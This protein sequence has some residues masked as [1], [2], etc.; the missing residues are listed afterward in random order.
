MP[1][2][3][4][5]TIRRVNTICGMNR[6]VFNGGRVL[7]I[8]GAFTALVGC[9]LISLTTV[10]FRPEEYEDVLEVVDAVLA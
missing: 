1:N 4:L 6:K 7:V 5:R 9:V 2:I 8:G 3:Y 10:R